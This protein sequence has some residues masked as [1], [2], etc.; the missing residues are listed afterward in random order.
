MFKQAGAIS[1]KPKLAK[2][3]SQVVMLAYCG[4]KD[5]ELEKVYNRLDY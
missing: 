3:S 4:L 1:P 2:H 5:S